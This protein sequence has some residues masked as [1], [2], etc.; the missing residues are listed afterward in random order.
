MIAEN[1]A[2]FMAMSGKRV[3]LVDADMRSHL[4]N[5][6]F[7][8]SNIHGLSYELQQV[9][10]ESDT[11]LDVQATRVPSL[12]VLTA[13]VSPSN[14]AELLQ[15]STAVQLFEHLK[16]SG[17]YDYIVIDTPPL[18]PVADAQIL[19]S[20]AQ[21]TILV[22]DASKTSRKV[23]A[24]ARQSL[25]RMRAHV[26]GVVINKSQWPD[27]SDVHMYRS[28]LYR[29]QAKQTSTKRDR[30]TVLVGPPET[31]QPKVL[32]GTVE[33]DA[34]KTITIPRLTNS[35]HGND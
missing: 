27:F 2:T 1:L 26:L 31:P 28:E 30:D 3:L 11:D 18:L 13:G 16:Q 25:K 34:D 4:L 23:L 20:Y 10:T 24:Q 12:Q 6:Y 7:Q 14:P 21:A 32:D 9:W 29:Q 19:A 22:V 33:N 17:D 5:K 35:L 15:S 8:Q